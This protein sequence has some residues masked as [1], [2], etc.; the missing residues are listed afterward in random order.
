MAEQYDG[1]DPNQIIEDKDEKHEVDQSGL[2]EI[3]QGVY[4]SVVEAQNVIE[5]HYLE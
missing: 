4:S 3:F 5:Q 1:V 2:D